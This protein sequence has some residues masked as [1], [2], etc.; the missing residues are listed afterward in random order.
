MAQAT[1]GGRT[2]KATRV[3]DL[4]RPQK[5]PRDSRKGPQH[6]GC[7]ATGGRDDDDGREGYSKMNAGWPGVTA[8]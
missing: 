1:M 2:T 7:R 8:G 5:H 3:W 6:V 4:R